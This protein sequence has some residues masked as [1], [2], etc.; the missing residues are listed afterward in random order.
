MD[1]NINS[2]VSSCASVMGVDVTGSAKV[3]CEC[4]GELIMM[5]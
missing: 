1:Q 5:D 3:I 4:L 2:V